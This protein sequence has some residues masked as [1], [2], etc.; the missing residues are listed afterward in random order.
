MCMISITYHNF[1]QS[2]S[3]TKS[4]PAIHWELCVVEKN[5]PVLSAREIADSPIP[6]QLCCK[7]GA[8]V[9]SHVSEKQLDWVHL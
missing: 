3:E 7:F 2:L 9:L 4:N 5:E 6:H 8:V 1:L